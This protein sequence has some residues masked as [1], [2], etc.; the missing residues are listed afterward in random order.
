MTVRDILIHP[1]QRLQIK[2][3]PVVDFDRH[4]GALAEDLL[5]TLYASGPAIGLCAPQIG[6]L[7]QVLVMDLSKE[8]DSP[9]FYVNPR[10]IMRTR[11]C[12]AEERCL[13]V[14]GVTANVW[15]STLVQVRAQDLDGKLFTRQLENMHAVCLQHEMDH[16]EGKTIARKV[17]I[18]TRLAEA[19]KAG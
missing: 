7:Q 8:R 11:P 3:R 19:L 4:L 1:D 5:D 16:F 15:R 18:F 17:S 14:P 12:F 13:S 2:A 9:E 10:L 6:T